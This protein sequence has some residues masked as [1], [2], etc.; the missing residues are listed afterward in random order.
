MNSWI[1]CASLLAHGFFPR[2]ATASMRRA[3]RRVAE[4]AI[5]LPNHASRLF[6]EEVGKLD[7]MGLEGTEA[8]WLV[9]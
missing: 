4:L 9:K 7:S 6:A 8:L 2:C 1:G 5:S 3:R